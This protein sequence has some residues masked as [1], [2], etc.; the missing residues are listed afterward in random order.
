LVVAVTRTRGAVLLVVAA[1]LLGLGWLLSP[2]SAPPLYDGVGFPD[3]PYRFVVAPAGAPKTTKAPTVATGTAPVTGGV[4]GAVH[5][6]SAEQAP[7]ISLLI[8]VGR[9]HAP[10][11]TKRVV[12]HATPVRPVTAPA[13]RFL[14]S[15]VYK[16]AATDPSVT[17]RDASPPATITM[18]AATAQRPRPVIARYVGG[19][20]STLDTTPVGNDIYQAVLPGLGMYAVI[21]TEQLDFGSGG[22]STTVTGILIA[23]AA[24]LV[25]AALILVAV[26]RRRRAT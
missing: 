24:V 12:L 25:V 17:M 21:G 2:R 13:N 19:R 15:D 16:L 20:W 23:V 4:A 8:P 7:Q 22:G 26:W 6:S 5:A 9:L 14:W 3:E 10:A 1:A 11:G 18:R